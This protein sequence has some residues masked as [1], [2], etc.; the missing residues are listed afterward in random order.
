VGRKPPHNVRHATTADRKDPK[1]LALCLT[2]FFVYYSAIINL[3]M[4]SLPFL[5][6]WAVF[7]VC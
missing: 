5:S 4:S 1:M 7:W 2:T 3:R 6:F